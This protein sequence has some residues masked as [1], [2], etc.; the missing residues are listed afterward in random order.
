MVG[1]GGEDLAIYSRRRV[2]LGPGW[3]R[4]SI[5]VFGRAASV[6]S[7]VGIAE[8]PREIAE[9]AEAAGLNRGETISPNPLIQM[10]HLSFCAK[11]E[12]RQ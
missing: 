6:Q 10:R 2:R 3:L 11:L 7:F 8:T 1:L 4:R 12:A 9:S 5:L